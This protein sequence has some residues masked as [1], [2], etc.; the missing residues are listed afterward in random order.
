ME[1]FLSNWMAGL[2]PWL[3]DHGIKIIVIVLLAF[4]FNR[5][6]SRIIRRAVMVA[7]IPDKS[8]PPKPK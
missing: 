2:I 8:L 1:E 3:M 5:I 7:V 4:V 6:I